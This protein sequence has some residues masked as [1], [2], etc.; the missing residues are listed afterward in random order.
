MQ[1][2]LS[3]TNKHTATTGHLS[4]VRLCG[5]PSK[6]VAAVTVVVVVAVVIVVDV[7]GNNLSGFA[8]HFAT[9]YCAIANIFTS[10]VVFLANQSMFIYKD[11]ENL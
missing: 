5:A 11:K 3:Q 10:C 6:V 8:S 2:Y 9:H 4:I 7:A 1:P